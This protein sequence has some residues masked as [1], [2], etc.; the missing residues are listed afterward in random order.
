MN[1]TSLGYRTDL[2]LLKL[3][4]SQIEEVGDHLVVR[5]PHNPT[6]WWGNFLL[7]SRPPAPGEFEGW[8]AE[9][10][11]AFPNAAHRTFGIDSTS[12]EFGSVTSE[13]EA[14]GFEFAHN[15][16][17]TARPADL[18]SPRAA[19]LDA[20]YRSLSSDDDWA[21]A[22]EVR[23]ACNDDIEAKSYRTYAERKMQEAR[24]LAEQGHGAWFGAFVTGQMKAGMG[25]Y[26]DGS[27]AARFQ[28]V[29]TRFSARGQG[30]ASNLVYFVARHGFAQMQAQ[31]LV[32]VADPH[33][34]AITLY[35]KL[36]FTDTETQLA[37]ERPPPGERI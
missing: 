10:Q 18:K 26:T 30:L 13:I 23:L 25:L 31:T 3:S 24:R 17:M 35:R 16:V 9:F 19:R 34:H 1:I 4:G 5:T 7:Y 20:D 11:T 32:M 6:F 37:L 12:G 22:L 15:T 29:E 36:G 21:Q 28:S 8:Q 14:G 27:G 33:Y 2:M